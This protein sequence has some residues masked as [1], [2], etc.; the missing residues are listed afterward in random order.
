[1]RIESIAA[2]ILFIIGMAVFTLLLNAERISGTEY[3]ALFI[4]AGLMALGLYGFKRLREFD[5]K[6]LRLVLA[7]MKDVQKSVYAKEDDLRSIAFHLAEILAVAAAFQGR[8]GSDRSN[9]L[10]QRWYRAKA[11]RLMNELDAPPQRREKVLGILDQF[12]ELDQ[13]DDAA[14]KAERF[15]SILDQIERDLRHETS[16]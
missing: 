3:V 13:I 10:K 5:L 7:E 14:Q 2:T 15:E 16:E 12:S 8:Y 9:Q 6:N 11:Q 4:A 1:M